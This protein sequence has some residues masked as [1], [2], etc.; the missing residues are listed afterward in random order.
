V[1][2]VVVAGSPSDGTP[3]FST[4]GGYT[5]DGSVVWLDRGVSTYQPNHPY[6][7]GD[8]FSDG[9]DVQQ[10]TTAGTSGGS[11]PPFAE[12]AGTVTVD[13][14]VV[15]TDEGALTWQHD[16][17]YT[18]TT[19]ATTFIVDPANHVQQVTMAGTSGPAQPTFNDGGM[20]SDA[21]P[22]V[23]TDQ[24]RRFWHPSGYT[25]NAVIVDFHSHVQFVTTAGTSGPTQP[26]FTSN[27]PNSGQTTDGLQWTD[28]DLPA[29]SLIQR[30][31]RL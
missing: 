23:W 7:V 13:N 22:L 19:P 3:I 8:A 24:G 25:A 30:R 28:Q 17:N 12:S 6:N 1:Q 4:T 16:H 15:W 18:A 27:F 21:T 2:Q 20:T 31:R 11:S 5:L 9:T 26:P 10:A 14:A 29:E